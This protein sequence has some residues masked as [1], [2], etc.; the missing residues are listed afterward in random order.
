MV[1]A[2][3]TYLRAVLDVYE[4]WECGCD[5]LFHLMAHPKLHQ[6]VPY[7]ERKIAEILRQAES[8]DEWYSMYTLAMED[9]YVESFFGN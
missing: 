6:F 7:F 2:V 5:G 8:E 3:N 1:Q 9:V 4:N